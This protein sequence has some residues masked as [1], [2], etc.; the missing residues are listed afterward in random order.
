MY[1]SL[2]NQLTQDG[3]NV[4]YNVHLLKREISAIKRQVFILIRI[5]YLYF[6]LYLFLSTNNESTIVLKNISKSFVC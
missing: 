1:L 5:I 6:I 3:S 4:F 2:S